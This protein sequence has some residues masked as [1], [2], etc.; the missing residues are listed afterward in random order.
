MIDFLNL[1]AHVVVSP[2]KTRPQL[3]A[4]IVL[5]RHQLNV[6]RR[7]VCCCSS[8]STGWPTKVSASAGST[9]RPVGILGLV[10]RVLSLERSL[11]AAGVS[12]M[13]TS[14]LVRLS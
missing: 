4:E 14:S 13:P 5:L 2:F 10:E 3:E 12:G 6:L 1:F 7:R 9:P 11:P 8:R